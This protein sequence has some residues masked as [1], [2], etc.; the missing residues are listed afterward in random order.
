M[1]NFGFSDPNN[2]LG[3]VSDSKRELR[4]GFLKRKKSLIIDELIILLQILSYRDMTD[5]N[6]TYFDRRQNVPSY[7]AELLFIELTQLLEKNNYLEANLLNKISNIK[8]HITSPT[9]LSVKS[10]QGKYYNFSLY[11]ILAIF[12]EKI[13]VILSN[14]TLPV[15]TNEKF[16]A[17]IS[18]ILVKSTATFIAKNINQFN[19]PYCE[20]RQKYIIS[21]MCKEEPILDTETIIPHL[22][23]LLGYS[24]PLSWSVDSESAEKLNNIHKLLGIKLF[25]PNFYNLVCDSLSDKVLPSIQEEYALKHSLNFFLCMKH[26][27]ALNEIK[28]EIPKPILRQI[29]HCTLFNEWN[30]NVVMPLA[31]R[32]MKMPHKTFEQKME[33]VKK[34][35]APQLPWHEQKQAFTAENQENRVEAFPEAEADLSHRRRCVI[36]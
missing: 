29:N 3:S 9:E 7:E 21:Q 2:I 32:K 35:S 17:E 36:A 24:R 8:D 18:E 22:H 20:E 14:Q 31:P 6:I 25:I 12:E 11:G 26:H 23:S 16:Q 10:F 34:Y 19:I 27:P 30:G 28:A 4:E 1:K 13:K 15:D 33:N 5:Y